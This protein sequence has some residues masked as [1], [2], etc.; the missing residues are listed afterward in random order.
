MKDGIGM[1]GFWVWIV[2]TCLTWPIVPN[3]VWFIAVPITGFLVMMVF[4]FALDK[5]DPND[6]GAHWR[7]Q[8]HRRGPRTS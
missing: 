3:H 7:S 1:L 5:P 4:L 8:D 6:I 2:G